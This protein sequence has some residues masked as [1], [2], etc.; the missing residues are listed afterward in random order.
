M[1][2]PI[3]CSIRTMIGLTTVSVLVVGTCLTP[4]SFDIHHDKA[5]WQSQISTEIGNPVCVL[6]LDD[7]DGHTEIVRD[8]PVLNVILDDNGNVD[9]ITIRVNLWQKFNLCRYSNKGWMNTGGLRC[10]PLCTFGKMDK[11]K[12]SD[13]NLSLIHISEPTRPY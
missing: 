10:G 5:G 11:T 4:V 13:K 6:A 1:R 12:W 7:I 9:V 2:W 8:A 3:N